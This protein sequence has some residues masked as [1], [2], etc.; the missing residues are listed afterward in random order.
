VHVG[1]EVPAALATL[2]EA[3]RTALRS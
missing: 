3:I 2:H 1:R